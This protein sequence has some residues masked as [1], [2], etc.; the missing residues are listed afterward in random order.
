MKK[1]IVTLALLC[2]AQTAPAFFGGSES[3]ESLSFQSVFPKPFHKK[4]YF[5]FVLTGVT[6]VGA[7][8]VTYFTGGAGAPAAATGVS[9][10]ASWVAGG[11]AGSYMAGLSTVGA[12]FGGNAMLGSAILNGISIGV[13]GG[14]GAFATLPAVAKVGVMASVTAST[15]DGVAF[16]QNPETQSLTYRIRLTV[17]EGLGSKNVRKLAEEF[18][19]VER[20][21]L[22]NDVINDEKAYEELVEMRE[23]LL[24]QAVSRGEQALKNR[25]SNEDLMVLGILTKNAARPD[26]FEILINKI[27]AEELDDAG[28]IY[29]LRA[30]ALIERGD[31]ASAENLLRESWRLNPYAI[32]QPLLLL[33]ILGRGNIEPREGE[34]L[35]IAADATDSFDSDKYQSAYSLVAINYRLATIYFNNKKYSKAQEYYEHA[36]A[37]LPFMQKHIGSSNFGNTIRIGIANSLH[38]QKEDAAAKEI[39]EEVLGS[40]ETDA[41]E[42]YIRSIYYGTI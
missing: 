6:V 19:D 16:F 10:V 20:E 18:V 37:E 9:S 33:N 27:D 39:F 5:G 1:L 41:E 13:V 28:Y 23:T 12:W 32:E 40:T 4:S 34:L 42:D 8:A 17:P 22:D 7:G 15:L 29:Y 14:G 30:V 35:G 2:A 3:L 25:G 11:G 24:T 38:G 26:L 21:L 31:V 36:Y